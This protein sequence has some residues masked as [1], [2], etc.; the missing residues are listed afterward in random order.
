[1]KLRRSGM[2]SFVPDPNPRTMVLD[3][4][5][6]RWVITFADGRLICLT[7][8]HDNPAILSRWLTRRMWRQHFYRKEWLTV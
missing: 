8:T 1:M 6:E 4:R 3:E 5:G 7:P 2:I